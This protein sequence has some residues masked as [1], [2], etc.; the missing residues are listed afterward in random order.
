M[1]RS[2]YKALRPLLEDD[3][4]SWENKSCH[5]NRVDEADLSMIISKISSFGLIEPVL[6]TI[7]GDYLVHFGSPSE[8]SYKATPSFEKLM[9]F[10]DL[11][12]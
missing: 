5:E 12:Q 10:L 7:D 8:A 2:L 11:E 6:A 4:E 3:W 1:A 9:K